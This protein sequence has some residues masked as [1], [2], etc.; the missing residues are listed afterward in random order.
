MAIATLPADLQT[1]ILLDYEHQVK[2]VLLVGWWIL[3]IVYLL[4]WY[5]RQQPTKIF[6]L[7]TFRAIIYGAAWLWSWLFWLLYP[8]YIHPDVAIDQLLIFLAYSYTGLIMIFFVMFVVNFT[9]WIPRFLIRF[10]K[11]DMT[12]FEDHAIDEFFGKG[13]RRN[14][15]N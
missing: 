9:L 7:G 5:K 11:F 1:L 15:K 10:G 3:S 8:V 2:I 13:W 4:F 12:G 14:G 6:I